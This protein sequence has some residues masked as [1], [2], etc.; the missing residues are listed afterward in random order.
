MET[1][2][3]WRGMHKKKKIRTCI[4][5]PLVM[6]LSKLFFFTTGGRRNRAAVLNNLGKKKKPCLL[7]IIRNHNH[8]HCTV[9]KTNQSEYSEVHKSTKALHYSLWTAH[10]LIWSEVLKLSAPQWWFLCNPAY[11][12]EFRL[13]YTVLYHH[14]MSVGITVRRNTLCAVCRW[15]LPCLVKVCIW[16]DLE[17]LGKLVFFLLY[18]L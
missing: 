3:K 6:Q 15:R 4:F 2:G 10:V 16:D 14:T 18:L 7:M 1:L 8:I 5:V 9:E 12:F 17:C 13:V 11:W